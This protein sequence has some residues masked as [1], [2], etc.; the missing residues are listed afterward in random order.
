MKCKLSAS[1]KHQIAFLIYFSLRRT[2][3]VVI[4][5]KKKKATEK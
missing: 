5:K 3:L 1:H 4:K 2:V